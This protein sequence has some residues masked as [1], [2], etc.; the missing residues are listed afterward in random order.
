MLSVSG[1]ASGSGEGRSG[2]CLC[3]VLGYG[4]SDARCCGHEC[5]SLLCD[6]GSVD[7]GVIEARSG[8]EAR[9]S[10]GKR[11]WWRYRT[12][13]DGARCGCRDEACVSR[14][15]QCLRDRGC[16]WLRDWSDRERT[17]C[18]RC[19]FLRGDGS[20]VDRAAGLY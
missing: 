13:W 12:N 7:A 3:S 17:R 15:R 20:L 11:S 5:W 4:C 9:S 1:A 6:E 18:D 14:T 19:A 8:Q 16:S 10:K 2:K